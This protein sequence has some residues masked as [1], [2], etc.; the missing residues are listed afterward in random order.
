VHAETK[1][2]DNEKEESRKRI[3]N[4]INYRKETE[5]NKAKQFL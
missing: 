2:K 4:K 3:E 1:R 5:G